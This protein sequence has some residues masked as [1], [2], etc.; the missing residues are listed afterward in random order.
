MFSSQKPF[1]GDFDE[2]HTPPRTLKVPFSE[3]AS[4]EN[5]PIC[6]FDN[7][8]VNLLYLLVRQM[9]LN[10]E[11]FSSIFTQRAKGE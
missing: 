5:W 8:S 2:I 11:R 7:Q 3:F 9:T 6:S 1:W 10:L 4:Q